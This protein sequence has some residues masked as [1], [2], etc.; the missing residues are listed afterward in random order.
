MISFL[1]RILPHTPTAEVLQRCKRPT[2]K[3]F[4]TGV[5]GANGCRERSAN[6]RQ[7][8]LLAR[9]GQE[10]KV[11]WCL[12][13]KKTHR[14]HAPPWTLPSAADSNDRERA[15]KWGAAAKKGSA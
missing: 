9:G 11:R 2:L 12:I 1:T 13:A 6:T 15:R 4:I 8:E 10:H 5:Q 7:D 14:T 3:S